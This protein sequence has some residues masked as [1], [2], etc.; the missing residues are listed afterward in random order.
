MVSVRGGE[1]CG[2]WLLVVQYQKEDAFFVGNLGGDSLW[3]LKHANESV[4]EERQ[5]VQCSR[6]IS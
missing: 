6:G 1:V 5:N 2:V 4:R 3:R